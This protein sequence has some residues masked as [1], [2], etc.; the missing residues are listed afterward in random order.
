MTVSSADGYAGIVAQRMAADRLAL[1][2]RW[3]ERLNE[4]LPVAFN[5]IFPS[6]QLSITF[7]YS[8]QKWPRICARRPK[9]KS[10]R[11]PP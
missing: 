6:E 8:W 1:A 10:L 4:F 5:D 11:M 7:P 3:L 9:R 2:G